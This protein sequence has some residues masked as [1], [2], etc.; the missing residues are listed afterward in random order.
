MYLVHWEIVPILKCHCTYVELVHIQGKL[1]FVM[2]LLYQNVIH[3]S[4]C[5]QM[6]KCLITIV[7]S[8]YSERVIMPRLLLVCSLHGITNSSAQNR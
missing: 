2:T 8:A 4:Y 1:L 6:G 7:S 3:K 5:V